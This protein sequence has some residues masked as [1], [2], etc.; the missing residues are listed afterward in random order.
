MP[1]S[2]P[3]QGEMTKLLPNKDR[4]LIIFTPHA[5]VKK[6]RPVGLLKM[7]IPPWLLTKAFQRRLLIVEDLEHFIKPGQFE[8]VLHIRL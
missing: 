4:G 1:K 6:N 7:T 3:I 2:F 8:D 5:A